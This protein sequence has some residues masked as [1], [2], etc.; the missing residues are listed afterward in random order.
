MPCV[1]VA[2]NHKFYKGSIREGLEA[3]RSAAQEFPGVRFLE[4]EAVTIGGVMFIGATP[5]S[6]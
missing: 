1:Y 3:G 4:N 2:G 6:A 5:A